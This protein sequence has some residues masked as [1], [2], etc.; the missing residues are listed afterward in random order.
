MLN[1][2]LAYDSATGQYVLSAVV[3]NNSTSEIDVDIATTTDS[4]K[5]W[6][7]ATLATGSTSTDMSASRSTAPTSTSLRRSQAA[8][9]LCCSAV[10]I[11]DGATISTSTPGVTSTQNLNN[12]NF[13]G[14]AGGDGYTYLLSAYS[15]GAQTTLNYQTYD[16]ATGQ[17]SATQSL[18]LAMATRGW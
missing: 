15:N 18:V 5:G 9:H 11:V 3:Y 4:S 7:V 2:R 16:V 13:Y 6:N 10:S 17:Y 1:T 14:V 12:G 8:G